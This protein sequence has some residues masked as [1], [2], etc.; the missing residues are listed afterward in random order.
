[1][2]FFGQNRD[3]SGDAVG[4]ALMLG[5]IRDLRGTMDKHDERLRA[6][7]G[8]IKQSVADLSQAVLRSQGDV[9]AIRIDVD[10]LT[11]TVDDVKADVSG[12]KGD[13]AEIKQARE[14]DAN[15]WAGPMK[16]ARNLAYAAAGLT[17]LGVIWQFV[18]PL[19]PLPAQ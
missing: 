16:L 1:M 9:G 11:E 17:A 6:E 13:V 5:E 19:F 4:V 18:L 12:L 7:I 10:R 15:K 14:V 3:A 2:A 8:G